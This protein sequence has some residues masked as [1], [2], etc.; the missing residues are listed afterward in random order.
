SITDRNRPNSKETNLVK[1]RTFSG[2]DNDDPIQWL[3]DLEQAVE[4]QDLNKAIIATRKVEAGNYYGTHTS[5]TAWSTDKKNKLI[6]ALVKQAEPQWKNR[7]RQQREVD[8]APLTATPI[9][10]PMTDIGTSTSKAPGP[11]ESSIGKLWRNQVNDYKSTLEEEP[12]R[13]E[14]ERKVSIKDKGFETE[15][16]TYMMLAEGQ[17]GRNCNNYEVESADEP[18][19]LGYAHNYHLGARE[20]WWNLIEEEEYRIKERECIYLLENILTDPEEVKDEF[21]IDE[22]LNSE[23][24]IT[25]SDTNDRQFDLYDDERYVGKFYEKEVRYMIILKLIVL[26]H[27]EIDLASMNDKGDKDP[28]NNTAENISVIE[29]PSALFI[30][31]KVWLYEASKEYNQNVKLAPKW[32]G[33]FYIYK[34]PITVEKKEKEKGKPM[35]VSGELLVYLKAN[36]IRTPPLQ[37]IKKKKAIIREQPYI[38]LV[39]ANLA[40]SDYNGKVKEIEPESDYENIMLDYSTPD[41]ESSEEEIFKDIGNMI[42]DL[43]EY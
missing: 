39:E 6:E 40:I 26:K 41:I 23:E 13:N 5:E 4:P 17:V 16:K 20:A 2:N 10:Q 29:K 38:D 30:G 15:K 21:E 42:K 11:T 34:E 32:K 18:Y 12:C 43:V 24:P 27:R 31:D 35:F 28:W 33:P 25:N 19:D 22:E 3:K 8:E 14:R 9:S 36:Y 37:K 7:L 1:V